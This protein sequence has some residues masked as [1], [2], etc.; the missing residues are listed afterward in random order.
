MMTPITKKECLEDIKEAIN[1]KIFLLCA[2]SIIGTVTVLG[3]PY[4]DKSDKSLLFL[5]CYFM[6]HRLLLLY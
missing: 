2:V 4:I 5:Y 3:K 6:C 1:T